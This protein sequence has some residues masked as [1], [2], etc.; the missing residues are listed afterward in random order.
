[1]TGEA[2]VERETCYHTTCQN[3]DAAQPGVEQK[4]DEEL[5]VLISNAVAEPRAVMIHVHNAHLE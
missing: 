5:L 2:Q 1:M 4:E 3:I